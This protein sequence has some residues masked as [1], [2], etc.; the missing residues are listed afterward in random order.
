MNTVD[1]RAAGR[2]RY[3]RLKL[4]IKVKNL[5]YNCLVNRSDWDI[6]YKS[7]AACREKLRRRGHPDSMRPVE[8]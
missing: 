5:C 6:G 1:M 3:L 8:G 2:R 4:K 7:C